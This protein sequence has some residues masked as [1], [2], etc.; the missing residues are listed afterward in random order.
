[1]AGRA[2]LLPWVIVAGGFHDHG[3]M[4]RANA[5]LASYLLDSGMRVHLVGHDIDSRFTTHPRAIPHVVTRPRGLPSAADWMLGRRGVRVARRVTAENPGA[6]VVVNG[7]N[8]PWPDVNWVHAVHAA[9]PVRDDGAP[10][11]S[12]Y[13]NTRQKAVARVRERAAL[14]QARLVIANSTATSTALVD[15]VGVDAARVRVVYLGSAPSAGHVSPAERIAARAALE[16]PAGVPVVAFVGALGSDIN[17][18]F[19]ILWQAWNTLAQSREWDA[20][21]VVA[22]SGWRMREWRD[23]ASRTPSGESVRFLGFTHDVPELL[24]AADLLVSP[25]RYE[26]YGLNVHEALCRDV[27]VMVTETAG[28]VERFDPQMRDA[29][30]PENVT[31][32]ALADR[33]RL[34]RGDMSAWRERTASTSARL[35]SRTWHDMAA[36]LVDVVEGNRCQSSLLVPDPCHLTLGEGRL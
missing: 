36:E 18:G 24:A 3:G 19:D 31:G 27:A 35:R 25:V 29:L 20:R 14:R 2:D 16:L 15:R 34:W 28:V 6:R 1:M 7:G 22:G 21:L 32:D 30:L 9:W 23:E 13:R 17:K 5:A 11:W 33:L 12:H 26:A 4:D 10:W 8:C